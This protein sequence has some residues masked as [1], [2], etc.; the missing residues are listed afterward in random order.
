[1]GR[2]ISLFSGIGC[3]FLGSRAL[4]FTPVATAENNPWLRKLLNIRFPHALDLGDVRYVD[5]EAMHTAFGTE[6][7]LLS[8]GFPCQDLAA[9][10]YGPGLKGK[11][12]GL[13]RELMRIVGE[14]KPQYVVIENVSLLRSKGLDVLLLALNRL[15][16]DAR[17]DCIPAAYV[18]APHVRDRIWITA[19]PR[20]PLHAPGDERLGLL[21][22]TGRVHTGKFG[23]PDAEKYIQKFP[24]SGT[25]VGRHVFSRGAIPAKRPK[26]SFPTPTFSDGTGG[27]GT[28]PKREGGMNLRTWAGGSLTPA[29]C[30]WAMGLPIDW[31]DP[32]V[33]S[34]QPVRPWSGPSPPYIYPSG[35]TVPDRG[36]RV[37]ACGNGLVPD[38]FALALE[39]LIEW[40]APAQKLRRGGELEK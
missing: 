14:A 20:S 7:T 32:T 21:N 33:R 35:C 34:P 18:G 28:S 36:K 11:R 29:F 30:E 39:M 40:D 1:M 2:H 38:V 25:M 22:L 10:G 8:G 6:G 13:Y 15:G 17:W 26:H 3:D 27:P 4:G 16:Y 31:T 12:S 5:G 24:R 9:P 37:S 23:A 19:A